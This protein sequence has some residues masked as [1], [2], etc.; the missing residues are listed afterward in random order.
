MVAPLILWLGIGEILPITIIFICSFFP[1][2][3][4]TST[5][6]KTVDKDYIKVAKTLGASDKE[7]LFSVVLPLA[8]P[9]IF[10]GLKLESGMAW[11]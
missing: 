6:I 11:R 8:L 1:I 5:G 2:L 7:V 9:N 3:Y 10:T 4:N